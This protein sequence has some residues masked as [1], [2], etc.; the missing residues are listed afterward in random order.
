VLARPKPCFADDADPYETCHAHH[1]HPLFLGGWGDAT[2]PMRAER[3][4]SPKRHWLLTNQILMFMTDS[5]W[6]S[7]RMCS[8]I[9]T[10]HGVGQQYEIDRSPWPF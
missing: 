7:C 8:S 10:K 9:L 5:T 6:R 4:A 2:K 1:R 3:L